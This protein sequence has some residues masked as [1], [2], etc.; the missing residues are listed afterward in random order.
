M[1]WSF[2]VTQKATQSLAY[3]NMWVVFDRQFTQTARS[4]IKGWVQTDK[5]GNILSILRW[6]AAICWENL[7]LEHSSQFSDR[8]IS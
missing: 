8:T 6:Q 3:L 7:H 1:P 5:T 4:T 2:Q